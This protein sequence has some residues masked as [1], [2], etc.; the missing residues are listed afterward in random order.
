MRIGIFSDVHG[1]WE[2][3]EQVL[4]ALKEDDVNRLYCAGDIVG[5]GPDP[6]LCM[7][8][9]KA[10]ADAV[11]AG[12]HDWAVTGQVS[13]SSFNEYAR[14][15]IEWTRTMVST[16]AEEYLA[17]L[18]IRYVEGEITAVHGTPAEPEAWN[19]LLD[20]GDVNR[21]F[22]A[23]TTQICIVGHSHIPV[24]FIRDSEEKISVRGAENVRIEEDKM[25]LINV[26]SVGQ[27]RDGDPRAAY[28]ILDTN[29]KQF[30]LKRI[31]YPVEIVQ[32]KMRRAGLPFRLINRL[33]Y[34]E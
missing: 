7:E 13:T 28:G 16:E 34:G 23:M 4:R 18:P 17:K 26:G 20:A 19:Y 30:R 6:N 22:D 15:A 9:I 21:N 11:V 29:D 31:R 5:Y 10:V 3:L 14:S 27:P 32:E 24:A 2:A 1:N 8:K 25:Y 33:A 12:N